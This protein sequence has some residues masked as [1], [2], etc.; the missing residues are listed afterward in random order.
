MMPMSP[1]SPPEELVQL[2]LADERERGR[3][4]LLDLLLFMEKIGRRQHDA[5]DV[6]HAALERVVHA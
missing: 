3:P 4:A 5:V 2:V 6:A 1:S